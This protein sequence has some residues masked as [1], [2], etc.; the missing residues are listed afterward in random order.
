M[1]LRYV[2]T[3]QQKGASFVALYVCTSFSRES[4]ALDDRLI[5]CYIL[6][7][8][9]AHK[10]LGQRRQH[11]S[12]NAIALSL[13]VRFFRGRFCHSCRHSFPIML[14]DA[15]VSPL[16]TLMLRQFAKCHTAVR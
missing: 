11:L 13:V 1:P 12:Y 14:A 2:Q 7:Y 8:I 16:D 5:S 6:E 3:V 15:D 9:L 10:V 4:A